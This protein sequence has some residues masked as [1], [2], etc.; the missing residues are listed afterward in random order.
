MDN[1]VCYKGISLGTVKDAQNSI[2]YADHQYHPIPI[3]LRLVRRV[4]TFSA[5]CKVCQ[6]L[7]NQIIDLGTDL[8]DLPG[9]TSQSLK[10]YLS[11][12]KNIIKHLKKAHG[13]VEERQYIKRYVLIGL[14]FGLSLVLLSLILLNFGITL[15]TLN[16]AL[17][18]M[19]TRIII[20]YIIGFFLD[21]RAKKLDKVL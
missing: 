3:I 6:G 14:T 1:K 11:I 18:A 12:V 16:V 19:V 20:G 13:L 2:S 10:G 21:R 5:E 15:L 17:M 8:A 9:R 7:Q 4:T